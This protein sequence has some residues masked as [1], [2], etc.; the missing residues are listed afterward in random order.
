LQEE[1]GF[2]CELKPVANFVY[3]AE[4]AGRGVE[5]EHVTVLRGSVDDSV[6]PQPDPHE[7]AMW[8][9]VSVDELRQDMRIHPAKYAPWF[10]CG[11]KKLTEIGT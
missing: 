11:M 7:V 3:R 4:D 9:W 6:V 8:T 10:H 2:S 5:H 1:L